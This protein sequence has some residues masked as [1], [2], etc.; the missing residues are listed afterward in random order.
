MWRKH[1]RCYTGCDSISA[2]NKT[3]PKFTLSSWGT[4]TGAVKMEWQP[5][6]TKNLGKVAGLS[7]FQLLAWRFD[8]DR[9]RPVSEITF[10]LVRLQIL[11]RISR[12]SCNS[13]FTEYAAKVESAMPTQTGRQTSYCCHPV[14]CWPLGMLNDERQFLGFGYIGNFHRIFFVGIFL[15]EIKN[16]S[17]VVPFTA[18]VRN[19]TSLRN[20][21]S[22]VRVT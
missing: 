14:G 19:S 16:G 2:Y 1:A 20:K 6:K 11:L 3:C 10:P 8:S 21:T 7:T 15:L 13:G 22:N 12:D 5:T 4:W 18:C 17:A 9:L